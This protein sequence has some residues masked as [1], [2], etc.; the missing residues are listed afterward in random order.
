MYTKDSDV[1][2]NDI[3]DITAK[4]QRTVPEDGCYI[5]DYTRILKKY[6]TTINRRPQ[7]EWHYMQQIL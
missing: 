6:K 5:I 3:G 4:Q 1:S 7:K 2:W